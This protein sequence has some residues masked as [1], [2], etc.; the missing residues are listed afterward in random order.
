MFELHA[1]RRIYDQLSSGKALSEV[2]VAVSDQ[3]QGQPLRDKCTEALSTRTV[4]FHSIGILFQSFRILSCDL[5]A[6]NRTKCT[7]CILD[8]NLNAPL[9]AS[10]KRRPKLRDQHPHIRCLLQAE[11]IDLLRIKG[12]LFSFVCIWVVQNIAQIQRIA[13]L[14]LANLFFLQQIT[15]SYHLI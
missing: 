11:I 13:M 7:V 2:V 9:C 1:L 15:S 12:H 6:K 14:I 10:F 5:R 8:I 4:T 3:L